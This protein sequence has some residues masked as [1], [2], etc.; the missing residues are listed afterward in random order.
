[1][2]SLLEAEWSHVAEIC[3]ALLLHFITLPCGADIFWK[4]CE[5]HFHHPDWKVRFQAVEKVVVIGRFLTVA[6][7]KQCPG[8]QAAIA[9]AFCFLL[10]S[11]D[12]IHV[13]V[14]QR[15]HLYLTS[16]PDS[17]LRALSWCL[18]QQF[19]SV[20]LDRPMIIQALHQLSSLLPDRKILAW[21]FFYNRFDALYLEAQIALEKHGDIAFPR[22]T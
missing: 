1:M 12:D 19:D 4:L 9:H 16:L 21:E 22:G 2:W 13:A 5:N 6:S 15:A 3:V 8:L 20:I 7:V 18:E 11:L 17:G 10:A 14:A